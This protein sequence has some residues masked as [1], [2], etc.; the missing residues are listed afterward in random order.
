MNNSYRRREELQVKDTDNIFNKIM[1]EMSQ[2][3]G[4]IPIKGQK[5]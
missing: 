2:I 3:Q 4:K 5:V 1:M